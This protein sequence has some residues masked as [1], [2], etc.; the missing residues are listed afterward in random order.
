[1]RALTI[2]VIVAILLI[3]ALFSAFTV[4][5]REQALVLRFG[6]AD[7]IEN[8]WGKEPDAGLK[9]RIPIADQIVK[10]DRRNLEI[11]LK[12]VELL[13]SDQERL[14]V[15]AFVRYRIVD[16]I[17]FYQSLRDERGAELKLNSVMDSTLRDVLGGVTYTQIISG[18][19]AELMESIQQ[20]S[21]TV[22]T[23]QGLGVEI[24]DVR[25]VRADLPKE[26]AEK[27]FDRMVTQRQQE[28]AG[29]RAEGAERAQEIRA[30]AEKEATLIVADAQQKAEIIRG[31]GDAERN[32]IYAEAFNQDPEFFSFYRRMDAYKKGLGTNT[33][34]VLSPDSDFL[35]YLDNSRGPGR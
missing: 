18:R 9:F 2:L 19:R 3:T 28:A 15:D 25:I 13:A 5:Q 10:M 11:D 29:I 16:P 6:K 31:E 27:V 30:T 21:N 24:I 8:G 22:A 17:K 34:Y 1:M 33:T 35:S 7:R 23:E 12:P 32:R 4:D 20:T 14:V 26:N